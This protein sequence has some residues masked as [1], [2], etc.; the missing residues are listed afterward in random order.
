MTQTSPKTSA[1]NFALSD[2]KALSPCLV[3][4]DYF[5]TLVSRVIHPEDVKRLWAESLARVFPGCPDGATV[6]QQRGVLETTHYQHDRGPNGN[7]EFRATDIYAEV[8]DANAWARTMPR[9]AFVQ[10]ALDLEVSQELAVQRVDE[11]IV[12]AA[13]QLVADGIECWL[14]S[15]FYLDSSVFR[16]FL[17]QHKL[18]GVFSRILVS[19]DTFATKRAGGMYARV[20]AESDAPADRIVMIGDNEYSD[21]QNAKAAGLHAIHLDRT[22]RHTHYATLAA[23]SADVDATRAEATRVFSSSKTV[24][25]ELALTLYSFI[26]RLHAKLLGEQAKD[27]FFLAREGQLLKKLF[28]HYQEHRRFQGN[29]FVR[30][31][32]LE[33]SRRSTLLPSLRPLQEETFDTLFRQYRRIS[34]LDFLSSLGLQDL[35]PQMSARL[36]A[37]VDDAQDDLP[38]SDLFKRAQADELFQQTYEC[39]RLARR[40]AF[41]GYIHSFHPDTSS[42][43]LHLVD[44]GW[45]G[46]IQDNI[47]NALARAASSFDVIEGHYIGLVA[48]GA[49]SEANIKSGLLFSC[50]GETSKNFPIYNEN[51]ALFEVVLAADHGSAFSYVRDTDGVAR[52]TRQDFPEEPMFRSK[53][54]PLQ[55]ELFELFVQVDRLFRHH[56]IAERELQR[57]TTRSHARM[58]LE[59]TAAEVRWFENIY[60]VENFGVFTRS[61]F[62]TNSRRPSIV[63]R[64]RFYLALRRQRNIDLLGFWP[65][66][67]CLQ[68]GGRWV[69]SRYAASR[70]RNIEE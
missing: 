42:H 69:A 68:Q 18:D 25:K 65:M 14:V 11:Q 51:R 67:T 32:Y 23:R 39:E 6:Y 34:L 13:R 28:D 33:V 60:H 15:D 53:I 29:A 4:F 7:S 26:D 36:G 20:L 48:S 43:V 63:D 2:I 70:L 52:A 44:V 5:D 22:A 17:V 31:H 1:Q 41:I 57:L 38:T 47:Y 19:S 10:L 27:V 56:G 40:D 54:E 24:F 61:T 66:L 12:G 37:S 58:V 21:Y 3:C 45:K 49:T 50:V 16:R 59:P 55:H 35:G 8:W 30:S 9:D 62:T 64:A 46:T